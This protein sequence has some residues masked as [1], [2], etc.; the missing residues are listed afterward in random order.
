[1]VL[2]SEINDE[3]KREI[4]FGLNNL[5]E[6]NRSLRAWGEGM[7]QTVLHMKKQVKKMIR[8]DTK[9]RKLFDKAYCIN[10]KRRPDRKEV[11]T[12]ELLLQGLGGN[13]VEFYEAVDWMDFRTDLETGEMPP[14]RIKLPQLAC[15]MSHVSIWKEC[16]EYEYERVLILEDDVQFIHSNALNGLLSLNG[17]FY[18]EVEFLYLGGNNQGSAPTLIDEG[19]AVCYQTYTTTAYIVS[20]TI[21]PELIRYVEKY[22]FPIDVALCHLQRSLYGKFY[23]VMPSIASQVSGYSDITGKDEDYSGV[24]NG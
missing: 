21:L 15:A 8:P 7:Y 2:S 5:K 23:I 14:P 17:L 19:L 16:L 20:K 13:Q 11:V 24:M 18:P 1:M 9:W 12:K 3:S 4:I 10:L 22:H 6:Q